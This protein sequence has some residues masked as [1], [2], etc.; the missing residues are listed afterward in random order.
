M[1]LAALVVSTRV[2][3]LP[4]QERTLVS[5][6]LEL[7][8]IADIGRLRLDI[9]SAQGRV[10][11]PAGATKEGNNR[12]RIQLRLTVPGYGPADAARLA[13]ELAGAERDWH[14]GLP[15]AR[16]LLLALIGGEIS[17]ATGESNVVV[18]V[19]GDTAL[20]RA[21]RSE[22]EI[23][24]GVGE[25]QKGLD[26]LASQ[27]AVRLRVD[28]LGH[29]SS[30]IGAVLATLPDARF[31]RDPLAVELDGRSASQVAQD[32]HFGDVDATSLVKVRREQARLREVLVGD[33]DEA[34]CALCGHAYP[35]SFLVAAHVKK[36][37]LCTDE[38]RR[39][40][41]HVAMLACSFGCDA[42]YETGWITVDDRGRVLAAPT[43]SLPAG[44]FRDLV[45]HLSGRRCAA[46]NERSE[47]YFSWHRATVFR[48][49]VG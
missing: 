3:G 33:R 13:A 17:T 49:G 11:L 19:H 24:V 40:L 23:P 39:D 37:A 41:L 38:E 2:S 27:G 31:T 43:E 47:V 9:T 4:E 10:G 45:H 6:P 32:R 5:G 42:L 44:R 22:H 26:L 1:L 16:T 21:E 25:V 8:T 36:R 29:R 15:D 35:L 7:A 34:H 28:E 14:P 30:F 12:K 18:G 48:G 20:V 46:H